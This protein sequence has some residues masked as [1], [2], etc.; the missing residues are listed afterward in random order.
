MV[1]Y[2]ILQRQPWIHSWSTYP[3]K[4]PPSGIR[5]FVAGHIKGNQWLI[6][7]PLISNKALF[8]RGGGGT[9]G[10]CWLTSHY[11]FKRVL[12]YT[13]LFNLCDLFWY[14]LV[15]YFV[16]L[17]SQ[18]GNFGLFGFARKSLC[19]IRCSTTHLSIFGGTLALP[20]WT[21]SGVQQEF[22]SQTGCPK[23]KQQK[24]S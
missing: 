23:I 16:T 5:V 9:L 19:Q 8:L 24:I 10:G 17:F 15:L 18:D 13:D 12:I 20:F 11:E 14:F 6:I 4:Y 22:S 2:Y 3:P 21:G 1:K 7:K